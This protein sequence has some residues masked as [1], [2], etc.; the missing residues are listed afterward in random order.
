MTTTNLQQALQS[1]ASLF[2]QKRYAEAEA[3]CLNILA[4]AP[5]AIDNLHLLALINKSAGKFRSA[6]DYFNRCLQ[7]EPRRADIL[8]NF[9]NLYR[10][11]DQP[12]EAISCY[13]SALKIEP[14]FRPARLALARQY[15]D[16]ENHSAALQHAQ[17]LLSAQ[18]GDHEALV[19]MANALRGLQRFEEAEKAYL[20][21]LQLKPDY[22]AASH[23]LGAMYVQTNRIPEALARLDQATACGVQSTTLHVNYA[24]ALMSQGKFDQAESMLM[25]VINKGLLDTQLIDLVTK[26]R[27]MRGDDHFTGAYES[28]IARQPD[29]TALRISF[30]TL[31]QGAEELDQAE[32]ILKDYLS[33]QAEDASIRCALAATQ[34]LSG[35]FDAAL[36]NLGLAERQDGNNHKTLPL[37]IDALMCLGRADEAKPLIHQGRQRFPLDQWYIAMEATAARLLGDARY[38]ELYNYTEFVQEHFLE[39]PAGWSSLLDFNNDLLAV[40]KKRHRFST[41]P[42]DQSLRHG[43]QTPTSLLWD[44]DPVIQTFLQCI[45]KPIAEYRASLRRDESHPLLSRNHGAAKLKGCWSVCLRQNGF[46]VNHVHPEGWLS[47]AYYA[48]TPEEINTGSNHAG[49]LQF[50]KPRFEV[51]GAAAEHF[52]KPEPGKLALFP[53]YMWHGT[54]PIKGND[55]RITIAFDVITVPH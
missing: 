2:N 1:A 26:L 23:N 3:L 24:T 50:G 12:A 44:H 51:P 55:P 19:V 29:N 25:D 48:E 11:E 22:G 53:S 7:I 41:H 32:K 9:G 21:S 40:L 13:E 42:L 31:L 5:N 34:T 28:C 4:N 8:A 18:P 35:K 49:W 36:E 27:F 10:I 46:H 30:A 20:Q 37:S 43:T 38:Q 15:N 6:E 17:Q 16:D 52:V 54:L 33:N 14:G 39:T 47:S 45:E